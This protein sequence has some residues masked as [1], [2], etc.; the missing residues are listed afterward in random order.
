M[1]TKIKRLA[2]FLFDNAELIEKFL[3]QSNNYRSI[4]LNL[5]VHKHTTP[6]LD[7]VLELYDEQVGSDDLENDAIV[8]EKFV[9]VC[10]TF[11]E[12]AGVTKL[13][14]PV[15]VRDKLEP[16]SGGNDGRKKE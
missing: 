10:N 5:R 3:C 4:D 8:K 14:E 13:S 6:E 2:Q 12:E 9:Q 16:E 11:N 15:K 7:T 1:V